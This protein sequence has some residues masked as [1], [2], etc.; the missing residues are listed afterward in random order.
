[1]LEEDEFSHSQADIV[2]LPPEDAAETDEDSGEEENV[3]PDNLPSNMLRTVAE[4]HVPSAVESDSD[5]DIPVSNLVKPKS[6]SKIPRQYHWSEEAN[7][8]EEAEILDD[9]SK[10]NDLNTDTNDTPIDWFM[11]L[12]D[13]ELFDLLI[14][15]SNRYASMKNKKNKPICIEEMKAFVG[16]LILS[17]YVQYPRRKMYWEKD[18]DVSNSLVSGALSRDRFDFIMSVLHIADNN[19]LDH[20][21]KFSK[22]RPLFTLLNQ[23]F[24]KHAVLEENHSIDEAMVPY[25]GRHGCKQFIKGKPIRWGYKLWVGCNKNG[26]ATW[27][28]PYQGASTHVSPN[29]KDFGVGAGVVLSYVDVLRSKWELKKFHLF[30]DNFFSTM[31]LFEMLTQKNIKGTGTI[32][33]NR[34]PNNPLKSAKELQKNKRGSYD[35]K[36]DTNKKLTIV[37]WH[38]NSVVSLCS[39]AVGANPTHQVKRYS[40]Q[41]KKP[42]LVPQP[43]MIKLYN[44]NMGG[45]DRCDQNISL[46]R[47]GIRGKKWY[48]CL[49]THCI[50]LAIQNAWQLHRSNEGTL[51]QL[52]FRRRIA[53]SILQLHTKATSSSCGRPSRRENADSRFDGMHHYVIDQEKQTKC[54]HCHKKTTTR[55]QKCDVGVHVRCFVSYHTNGSA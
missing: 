42:I 26:Y 51:D 28:E 29:Y 20:S 46:Y 48:F 13:E 34:I 15:E 31:P 23:N 36:F 21:D 30:F 4:I 19:N 3:S 7:I 9:W 38:D 52:A 39:N 50:D 55:C 11:K 14:V 33:S 37:S 12:F 2:L 22:V 24:L 43:F 49:F 54:R 41:E 53:T 16:I 25:F 27:F 6:V 40:R 17:G 47:T 1:M 45:V 5:D 18:K 10:D 32:R 8:S 35:A 44:R